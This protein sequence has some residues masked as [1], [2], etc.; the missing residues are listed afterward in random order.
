MTYAEW[1]DQYLALYKR[2]LAPKTR[3]SYKRLHQL[4]APIHG[5]QLDELTPD[6]LQA[7]LIHVDQA[8]GSRQSQLA[9]TLLHG[10]LSRAVRSG[11]IQRN[12]VDALDKPE[13]DAAEGKALSAADWDALLP[14]IISDPAF[15]LLALAGLRRGEV[16]GLRRADV[17]LEAG[18]LRIRRQRLRCAGKLITQTP[19]SKSGVRDVPILPELRPVLL[20]A[21]RLLHP[22]AYLVTCAPETLA[23]RWRAAQL[24]AG[25][26]QPYR[27]HDLRH[28]YATHMVA[29]GCSPRVLQYIIGHASL[30]LTMRVYTHID[31]NIA[32]EE[33]RRICGSLH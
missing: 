31:A 17:D 28:T 19:K 12:P 16:L 1:F 30:D 9:Y 18:L 22:S 5:A 14:E 2:K 10:A 26:A 21:C 4:L 7:A 8:A 24:R 15:A 33:C 27:L 23:R 29:R 20:Q 6:Q 25:I 11:H 32:L 13:H 3:E